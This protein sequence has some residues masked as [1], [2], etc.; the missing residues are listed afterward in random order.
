MIRRWK[1]E[2]SKNRQHF[3][4]PQNVSDFIFRASSAFGRFKDEEFSQFM[5]SE[6]SRTESPIEQLFIVAINLVCEFNYI[7]PS[8]TSVFHDDNDN[9][10]IIPQWQ[11]GKYR[12]DFALRRHPVDKIVC[13][14][15]D[16]HEF[17]DRDERQRR[18]EKSRDRFLTASGYSVLHFTG[19]EIV[20]DPCAAAL[21]TYKLASDIQVA[22]DD[23]IHPF[24]DQKR[25]ED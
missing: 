24:E 18:Y 2:V 15:L 20:K 21:E 1:Q 10:L 6:C 14:E 12:V 13:V 8:I 4:I 23:A 7:T 25:G 5:W 3:D 16:G 17:H 22:S 19:S 11:A 9:L